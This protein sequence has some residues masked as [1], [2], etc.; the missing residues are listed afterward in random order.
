MRIIVRTESLITQLVFNHAL[1]VRIEAETADDAK[2]KDELASD[3]ATTVKI[4]EENLMG[5]TLDHPAEG[6]GDVFDDPQTIA[7]E[8][9][10]AD[11]KAAVDPTKSKAG[12]NLVGKINNLCTS[13]L[14]NINGARDFLLLC[15]LF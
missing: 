5:A 13:D 10:D 8:D 15:K 14:A 11:V 12:E 7:P 1:R 3:E 4:R 9:G 6:D 2:S